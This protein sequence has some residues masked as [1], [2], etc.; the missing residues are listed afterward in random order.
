MRERSAL[1]PLQI[2]I[3]TVLLGAGLFL[4]SLERA[5][6]IEL[7]FDPDGLMVA[8]LDLGLQGYDRDAGK[9]FLRRVLDRVSALPG[10]ESVSLASAIPLEL[11][12]T[13]ISVQ[14]EGQVPL[15]GAAPPSVDFAVVH[16]GYFRTLRAPLLERRDFSLE[17][18]AG[19]RPVVLVN[20][21]LADRYWPGESAVGKRI[22][23]ASGP[24]HEV[25][26]VVKAG[27]YLTLGEE[28]KPFLFFPFEQSEA[29]AM[30]VVVRAARPAALLD[31]LRREIQQ[32]DASL[33]VYN[34]K[35]M[36]EHL[37]LALLPGRA[38]AALLGSFGSLALLL[39]AVGL[40]GLLAYTV[41]E[42]NHEFG[43]RRALGA[44]IRSVIWVAIRRA[45]AF[46]LLGLAGG[47]LVSLAASRLT[48]SLLY[49]V[50]PSDPFTY[51]VVFLLL[52]GLSLVA[53]LV[54]AYRAA[55]VDPSLVLRSQ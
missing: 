26:G 45:M 14:P 5:R 34:A 41:S 2:A 43:V 47:T 13:R 51:A 32:R 55:R 21:I 28:P 44:P 24:P 9:E 31:V 36:E 39:A 12:I 7:G 18:R 48:A 49:G 37:R 11:N 33:P 17:D 8:S 10:V 50:R 4:R 23:P 1:L 15:P 20:E 25:V 27:K 38:G 29:L 3:T 54:P 46:V 22:S 19:S 35:T 16:S 6:H 52:S 53:S 30:T 40:Y 42:R